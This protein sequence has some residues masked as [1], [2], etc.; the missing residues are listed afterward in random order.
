MPT[1]NTGKNVLA[2]CVDWTVTGNPSYEHSTRRYGSEITIQSRN[3]SK[4]EF[5]HVD[6]IWKRGKFKT[7]K[8]C[9]DSSTPEFNEIHW[10]KV[11][12]GNIGDNAVEVLFLDSVHAAFEVNAPCP[13]F[14]IPPMVD[15]G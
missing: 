5:R 2:S 14:C 4:G 7:E 15:E 9:V 8:P 13:D 3:L 1:G 10:F 12:T 11:E 6:W